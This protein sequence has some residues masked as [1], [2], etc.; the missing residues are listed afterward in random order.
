[1]QIEK[2]YLDSVCIMLLTDS[3]AYGLYECWGGMHNVQHK[4]KKD[5]GNEVKV[6]VPGIAQ[7]EVPHEGIFREKSW[8][9]TVTGE[10]EEML[11]GRLTGI[12]LKR[13]IWLIP[14]PQNQSRLQGRPLFF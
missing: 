2:F 5:A 13:A 7:G 1:M 9:V 3:P 12:I 8:Q 14:D 10:R 6:S 4:A 11:H